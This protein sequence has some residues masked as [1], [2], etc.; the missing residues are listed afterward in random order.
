[1]ETSLTTLPLLL[2]NFLGFCVI[3]TASWSKINDSKWYFL[4]RRDKF[5]TFGREYKQRNF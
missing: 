1:M 5:V 4:I 2:E 3:F